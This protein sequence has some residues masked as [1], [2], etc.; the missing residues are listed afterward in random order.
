MKTNIAPIYLK[1]VGAIEGKN[2]YSL[3]SDD[4]YDSINKINELEEEINKKKEIIADKLSIIIKELDS[5]DERRILI[6]LK[7]NLYNLRKSFIKI[8]ETNIHLIV[9]IAMEKDLN[10]FITLHLHFNDQIL[11][12]SDVFHEDLPLIFLS[13][14]N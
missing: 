9:R 4:I 14:P 8:V 2:A 10:E 3:G 7:R 6:N 11:L 13:F 1:R 12:S 5:D